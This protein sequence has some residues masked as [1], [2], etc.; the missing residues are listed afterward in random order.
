MMNIPTI[1]KL[2]AVLLLLA[3]MP[4]E[5]LIFAPGRISDRAGEAFAADE[6]P[7]VKIGVKERSEWLKRAVELE[8]SNE[9]YGLLDWCLEWTKNEPDDVDAWNS[10]GLAYRKLIRYD[11]AIDAYLRALKINPEYATAWHNLGIAYGNLKR[12][13]DAIDAYRRALRFN[14][15]HAEAWYNLGIAYFLSGNRIAALHTVRELRRRDPDEA[16][17]LFNLILPP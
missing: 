3:T 13:N 15:E 14:P 2:I 9:K 8:K 12:Y 16:E 4:E 5:A 7:E 11:D 10:L 17:R 1:L 6:T